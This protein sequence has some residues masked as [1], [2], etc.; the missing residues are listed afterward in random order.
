ML[1]HSLVVQVKQQK[2]QQIS[3]SSPKIVPI[4]CPV[5]STPSP[6]SAHPSVAHEV[7]MKTTANEAVEFTATPS[8]PATV[9]SNGSITM[10]LSYPLTP[11]ES[12]DDALAELDEVHNVMVPLKRTLILQLCYFTKRLMNS[13]R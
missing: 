9:T 5:A 7:A 6:L 13:K 1:D 4:T 11:A 8:T 12:H 2:E 3:Q 10:T